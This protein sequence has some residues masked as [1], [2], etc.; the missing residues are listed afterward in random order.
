M[1]VGVEPASLGNYVWYDYNADGIQDSGEEKV[2]GV[3]VKLYDEF[4]TLLETTLTDVN[5][6]YLFD[7]LVP[8]NYKVSVT[9]ASQ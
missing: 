3:L 5:G 9:K 8:G 6:E 7:N 4:G 1:P 2:A